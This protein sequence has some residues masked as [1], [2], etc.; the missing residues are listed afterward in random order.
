[1]PIEVVAD[2]VALA[3]RAA[4]RIA[5]AVT[6]IDAP[7]VGLP[8]G[9]TPRR[10]Y[11]E[12]ARR[13]AAG[14]VDFTTATFWAVDEFCAAARDA[15]GTNACYY[16]RHLRL[17]QRALRCPDAAAAD[18]AAE[19]AAHASAIRRAGGLDLC[20]LGVG[21]NGHVAFNEPGSAADTGARVVDLQP[22]TREAHAAP[23]GGI[24]R[25]PAAGMTLGVADLLAARALLVIASG[26][27][28]AAVVAPAIEGVPGA[29]VP[30]SWLR[31]HPRVEW[32]LDA[33][34][35]SGLRTR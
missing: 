8:T 12:L 21:R 3:R 33:A 10:A 18:P 19:I 15:P 25:V 5:H 16:A 34:A 20:V 14:S 27:A 1:M 9:D 13:V 11:G 32:L 4:D 30:A 2:D 6:G 26:E 23:F 35:A 28:K 29:D 24:A 22:A 31:D 7:Q 17:G